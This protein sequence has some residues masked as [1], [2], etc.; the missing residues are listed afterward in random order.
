[1]LKYKLS[2]TGCVEDTSSDFKCGFDISVEN[3]GSVEHVG[4]SIQN[5]IDS[6]S[7]KGTPVLK[8]SVTK[9]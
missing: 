2:V 5:A 8:D 1:M 3:G 4:K 9:E 7:D 6:M